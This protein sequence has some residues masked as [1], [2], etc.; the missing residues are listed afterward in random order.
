M[1]VALITGSIDAIKALVEAKADLFVENDE[2]LTPCTLSVK[3]GV[4]NEEVREEY[5]KAIN[6]SDDREFP[7]KKELCNRFVETRSKLE[8]GE[9][10]W[11]NNPQLRLKAPT[12]STCKV[13]MFYDDPVSRTTLP[14]EKC[15]FLMFSDKG[16]HKQVTYWHDCLHYGQVEPLE[17][18]R[19]PPHSPGLCSTASVLTHAA[20]TEESPS[21]TIIPFS[22]GLALAGEWSV[23][24]YSA[25]EEVSLSQLPEWKHKVSREVCGCDTNISLEIST[26]LLCR[27]SGRGPVQAAASSTRPSPTTRPTSSRF[28]RRM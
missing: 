8:H 28:L 15:G 27:E 19:G 26:D 12:G 10:N 5:F 23:I 25:S 2:K 7:L 1:H 24:V 13:L 4:D 14:M 16:D 17:I 20:F 21:Y 3:I 18:G 6:V 9:G 11:Q 22:K